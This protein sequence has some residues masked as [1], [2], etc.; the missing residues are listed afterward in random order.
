MKRAALICLAALT[1]CKSNPQTGC[2][3]IEK[4]AHRDPAT[5]AR[6]ALARGDRH[7]LALGGF[8]GVV[9][10]AVN[11]NIDQAQIMEGT[12]DV[13]TDACA[14][15]RANAETYATKYNQVIMGEAGK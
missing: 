9:P 12:S 5:D 6:A 4:L 3:A 11:A 14:R 7:L 13:R 10:G 1:S 15:Q 2:P 8:V